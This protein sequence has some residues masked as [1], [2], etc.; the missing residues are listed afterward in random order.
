MLSECISKTNTASDYRYNKGWQLRTWLTPVKLHLTLLHT[1]IHK[2]KIYAP[3]DETAQ[4]QDFLFAIQND[5]QLIPQGFSLGQHM[6]NA[7][8]CAFIMDKAHKFIAF[9]FD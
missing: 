3:L 8:H 4:T 6:F 5:D 1:I 2:I 7:L 9:Q